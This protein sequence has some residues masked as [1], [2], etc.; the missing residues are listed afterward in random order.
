MGNKKR[1]QKTVLTVIIFIVSLGLIILSARY[2]VDSVIALA[3]FFG[4]GTGALAA[5]VIAMGTSL[6]EISVAVSSAK[7]GNF[8]M[9]IGNIM[10][11]NIFNILVVFGVVGLFTNIPV[12]AQVLT[13]IL[14]MTGAAILTQWLIT[15]DKKITVTEGLMMTLLYVAFIGKLFKIF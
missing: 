11:S 2:V 10:G 4:L 14:P 3:S 9:V 13:F 1:K 8:D 5:S 6:P 7:K 12:G 15:M